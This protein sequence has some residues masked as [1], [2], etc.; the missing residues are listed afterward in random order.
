MWEI[1]REPG[2]DHWLDKS[3]WIMRR[4]GLINVIVHPDY[5]VDP[6]RLELYDSFLAFLAA[7]SGGWHALPRDIALWWRQRDALTVVPGPDGRPQVAGTSDY[8]A[9]VAYAHERDGHV[10]FDTTSG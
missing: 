4:H 7:Q 2:I 10:V 8:K 9:T 3:E 1:L 5:V 6:H